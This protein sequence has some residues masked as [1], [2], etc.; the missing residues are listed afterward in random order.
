MRV[1]RAV[2]ASID[3]VDLVMTD[4]GLDPADRRAV[5]EAGVKVVAA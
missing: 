3:E 1:A 4:V 5:E 2:F